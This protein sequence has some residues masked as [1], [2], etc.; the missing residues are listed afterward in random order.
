MAQATTGSA[1]KWPLYLS[2]LHHAIVTGNLT[3]DPL[4]RSVK[5]A[6]PEKFIC[7][8]FI[9]SI[10]DAFSDPEMNI[11]K[12]YKVEKNK[13]IQISDEEVPLSI[14]DARLFAVALART[15]KKERRILVAKLVN[16][17]HDCLESLRTDV[18]LKEVLVSSPV[19]SGFVARVLT[20]CSTMI[21]MGPRTLLRMQCHYHH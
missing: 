5:D 7:E 12:K 14:R 3:A 17:L 1:T 13:K 20:V 4:P 21:D 16:M 19:Y 8:G 9:E 10:L 6:S 2:P 15:P 18:A 11:V